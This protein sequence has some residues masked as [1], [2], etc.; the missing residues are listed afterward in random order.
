MAQTRAPADLEPIAPSHI[1][2]PRP[3]LAAQ[4]SYIDWGAVLAGTIIGTAISLLLLAFG[5]AIGLASVSPW[6]YS[7]AS[8]KAVGWSTAIW[9]ALVQLF[10]YAVGGYIA[11]R[12]RPRIGDAVG[13]EVQFRDAVNGLLVW[14]LG[15]T[16]SVLLTAG[17]AS[18]AVSSTAQL[19]GPAIG[20]AAG[21]GVQAAATTAAQQ[22]AA[23]DPTAA[24][25]DTMFRSERI[26]GRSTEDARAEALRILGSAAV[27]G[28]TITPADRTYLTRLVAARTGASPQDVE[29]RVN[30]ALDRV[31]AAADRARQAA[32]TARKAAAFSGFWITFVLFLSALGAVW[33]A[34]L[35][36]EHR[37]QGLRH[38]SFGV[39]PAFPRT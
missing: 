34:T 19:A 36:G 15:V 16:L 23:F 18:H 33:A 3:E 24:L 28:G 21:A 32:D 30:E 10:A 38:A 20:T 2:A 6:P 17:I 22:P 12:M 13:D 7:G 35:G 9:F 25:V 39:R 4:R 37:D 27:Q 8:A 31:K 26:D 11:A 29:A 1:D 14:G 5:A